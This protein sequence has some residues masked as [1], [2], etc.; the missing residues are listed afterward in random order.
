MP[1]KTSADHEAART[2]CPERSNFSP[3]ATT[4]GKR[5]DVG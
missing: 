5:V 4:T 1:A 2:S 3:K